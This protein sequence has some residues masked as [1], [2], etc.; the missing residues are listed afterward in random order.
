MKLLRRFSKFLNP[1]LLQFYL[2]ALFYPKSIWER[3]LQHAT[4][5]GLNRPVFILSF[6]CDTD[7]DI[8][9]VEGVHSKLLAAGIRPIYAVPGE[10]LIQGSEVYRRISE[11]GAEF[12]NHGYK[13]HSEAVSYTHLTLPTIL[14]V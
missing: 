1:K 3:N 9:V 14:R 6:D 7:L 8:L 5:L 12:I 13:S 11:S 4:R 2:L 10:L